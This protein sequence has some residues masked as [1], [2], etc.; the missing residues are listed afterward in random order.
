MPWYETLFFTIKKFWS[1]T[2]KL[3]NDSEFSE[4]LNGIEKA[5]FTDLVNCMR[6]GLFC[7]Y[8]NAPLGIINTVDAKQL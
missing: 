7:D 1:S 5:T 2:A 3:C 4:K 8:Y 6:E